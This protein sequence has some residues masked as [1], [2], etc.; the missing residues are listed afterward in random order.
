MATDGPFPELRQVVLDATD[1]RG[2][3]EFYRQLLGLAYRPGDERPPAG[4]ADD[5]GGEW[6]LTASSLSRTRRSA[7]PAGSAP[8]RQAG[9]IGTLVRPAT[10]SEPGGRVR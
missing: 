4:E 9:R 5:K 2:L 1:G 8:L 3:A 7:C 6:P 10:R